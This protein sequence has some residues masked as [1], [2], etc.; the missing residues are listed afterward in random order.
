MNLINICLATCTED[1]EWI[2]ENR[3]GEAFLKGKVEVEVYRGE[4]LFQ[5][6]YT[7][8]IS[9]NYPGKKV[10]F[11]V[12]GKPSMLVYSNEESKKLCI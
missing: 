6:I 9:R 7:R 5:K 4:G 1:G 3:M 12:Y 10:N 2:H 8:D 11:M